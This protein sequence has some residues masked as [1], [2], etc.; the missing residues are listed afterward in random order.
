MLI[1]FIKSS[2]SFLDFFSI[3]GIYSFFPNS[4]VFLSFFIKD[5]T[6]SW[7]PINVQFPKELDDFPYY[8]QAKTTMIEDRI[9]HIDKCMNDI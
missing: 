9:F 3:I 4:F 2:I 7:H 1:F 6:T 5:H 8:F